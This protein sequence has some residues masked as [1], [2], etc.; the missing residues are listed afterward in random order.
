[1]T[2]T[3]QFTVESSSDGTTWTALTSYVVNATLTVGRQRLTDRY[4]PDVLSVEVLAPSSGGPTLPVVRN[5]I[6]IFNSTVFPTTPLYVGVITDVQRS[7]G[8]PYTTATQKAPADRITITAAVLNSYYLGRGYANAQVIAAD[9]A[10]STALNNVTTSALGSSS[11]VTTLDGGGGFFTFWKVQGETFSGIAL[12]YINTILQS[13]VS[14]FRDRG[15][16]G[17]RSAVVIEGQ[18]VLA[19]PFNFSDGSGSTTGWTETVAYDQI[20]FVASDDNSYTQ[21]RMAYNNGSTVTSTSGSAPY[22]TYQVTSNTYTQTQAQSAADYTLGILQQTG[23]R[24]FRISTKASIIG[25]STLPDL[26]TSSFVVNTEIRI[27]FRGTI[28]VMICEGFTISQD[29]D[30]CRYT[31]Y[32]SPSLGQPLIL[33]SVY[34]GILDTNTLGLG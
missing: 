29:L 9:T 21:V 33:D 15:G 19:N 18:N 4:T 25:T 5:Q 10:T 34:L 16:T 3:G 7:Y 27:M 14:R 12:D 11:Y 22:S 30:D 23:T 24:P 2:Y 32:F 6:R 17:L 26:M 28:Y 31:F 8:I 20:E 13:T 1:M